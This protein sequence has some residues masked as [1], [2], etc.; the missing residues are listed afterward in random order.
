MAGKIL[1]VAVTN[2]VYSALNAVIIVPRL[3]EQPLF[4]LI[5][6]CSRLSTPV[7]RLSHDGVA[8]GAEPSDNAACCNGRL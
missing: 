6:L 7:L 2:S 4:C 5:L 3:R 8:S 1:L